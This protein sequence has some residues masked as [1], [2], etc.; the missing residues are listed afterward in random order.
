M[1]MTEAIMFGMLSLTIA[2]I[3][4]AALRKLPFVSA[5]AGT[6]TNVFAF[7]SA[8][9]WRLALIDSGKNTAWLGAARYPLVLCAYIVLFGFGCVCILGGTVRCVK[10]QLDKRKVK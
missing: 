7:L 9:N 4:V 1:G 10:K 6:V 5:L 2:V 3:S 8:Y